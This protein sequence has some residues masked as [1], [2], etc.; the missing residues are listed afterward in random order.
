MQ[1]TTL[2]PMHPPDTRYVQ[3]MVVAGTNVPGSSPDYAL[4]VYTIPASELVAFVR[5][6]RQPAHTGG[7]TE[8]TELHAAKQ[9][10]YTRMCGTG[11]TPHDRRATLTAIAD[12]YRAEAKP[13]SRIR[14]VRV[15]M[16][17]GSIVLFGGIHCVA[18]GKAKRAKD[19]YRTVLYLNP[20]TGTTA[21]RLPE[22]VATEVLS[23]PAQRNSHQGVERALCEYERSRGRAYGINEE[24]VPEQARDLYVD[25]TGTP[26]TFRDTPT[27]QALREHGFV[28]LRDCLSPEQ[29]L[30]LHEHI[31]NLT[32]DVLFGIPRPGQAAAVRAKAMG[33]S[34]DT[35]AK[36]LYSDPDFRNARYFDGQTTAQ[37]VPDDDATT[38]PDV[39]EQRERK[40]RNT[41]GVRGLTNSS[42]MV[43]VYKH[44]AFVKVHKAVHQRLM[45]ELGLSKLFFGPERCGLR[46]Y[47]SAEL[48][49]HQDEPL[50]VGD[51][52]SEAAAG[53]GEGSGGAEGG[54][55][56]G[57][58]GQGAAEGGPPSKRVRVAG[59][60]VLTY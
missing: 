10:L 47:K 23:D 54:C 25:P 33:V 42:G 53:G 32:R 26:P 56:D 34:L 49:P 31:V 24:T 21:T 55:G 7:T 30:E 20:W 1:V 4:H 39:R 9:R 35:F 50:V 28:V 45:T 40:R 48:P 58:V 19:T 46:A 43:D 14:W 15:P 44:P 59:G 13:D 16:V 57:W 51:V 38:P 27:L 52:G 37:W 8:A 17:P 2:P 22:T 3:A 60:A 12:A 6:L 36:T 5:W 41:R 29:A 18:G 11:F